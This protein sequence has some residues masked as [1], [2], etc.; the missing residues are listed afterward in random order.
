[1]IETFTITTEMVFANAEWRRTRWDDTRL[2]ARLV[3]PYGATVVLAA[4]LAWGALN[5]TGAV[6]RGANLTGAVLT[7]ANLTDADLTGANLTGANLRGAI[8]RGAVLRDANLTDA[9]LRGADLRGAEGLPPVPT[10]AHIDAAILAAVEGDAARGELDMDNWH[11]CET[12]HCRAGWAIVLAGEAGQALEDRVGPESAGV[13]IYAAS[14]PGVP[15]P[16]FFASTANALADLRECAA[17]DPLPTGGA[18]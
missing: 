6:L 17:R 8:L 14:R 16:N 1:M 12:T 5:L 4:G 7:G 10:V 11:S 18:Q 13:L 3:V 9:D 15:V 2:G